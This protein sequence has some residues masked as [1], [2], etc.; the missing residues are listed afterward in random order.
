MVSVNTAKDQDIFVDKLLFVLE[1]LDKNMQTILTTT[2]LIYLSTRFQT[3]Y[4]SLELI[5][6][7][8]LKLTRE[9]NADKNKLCYDK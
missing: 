1:P 6:N 7:E 5:L 4:F 8:I 9:I 2:L 3:N